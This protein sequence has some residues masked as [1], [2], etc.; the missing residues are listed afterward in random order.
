MV[1]SGV[2]GLVQPWQCNC[3]AL[4]VSMRLDCLS[5]GMPILA[6]S[7][8]RKLGAV[9]PF[10]R[11]L[12]PAQI[13]INIFSVKVMSRKMSG[14]VIHLDMATSQTMIRNQEK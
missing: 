4:L 13:D 12:C 7:L 1:I 10:R 8:T 11:H 3:L 9:T 6:S 14:C 2:A 5:W